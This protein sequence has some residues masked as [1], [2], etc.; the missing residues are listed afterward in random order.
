V[1]IDKGLLL[2]QGETGQSHKRFSN[3]ADGSHERCGSEQVDE[4][5][6]DD[7]DERALR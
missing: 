5:I 2:P 4:V 3:F 6:Q 7:R 1:S